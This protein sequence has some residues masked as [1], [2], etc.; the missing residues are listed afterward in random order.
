MRGKLFGAVIAVVALGVACLTV[1]IWW[2]RGHSQSAQAD[3]LVPSV[4]NQAVPDL[5]RV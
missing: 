4:S 5:P 3:G 2:R 1:D